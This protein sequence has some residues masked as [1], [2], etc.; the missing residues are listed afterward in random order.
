M[1]YLSNIYQQIN[2]SFCLF[3]YD[4]TAVSRCAKEEIFPA[5]ISSGPLKSLTKQRKR[6]SQHNANY[7]V[8]LFGTKIP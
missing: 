6:H 8:I 5:G 3:H 4:M 1:V 2:I 7:A